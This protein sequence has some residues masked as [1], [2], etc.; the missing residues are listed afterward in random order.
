MMIRL[1]K[2]KYF[3]PIHGEYRHLVHHAELARSTEIEEENILL[4]ENGNVI[5]FKDG[6]GKISGK[7]A[8]GRVLVDGK[9]VG[10]AT[11]LNIS[12]RE[13]VQPA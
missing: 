13:K 8:T 6:K 3:I 5:S 4:A 10:V 7:V 9:G 12:N 1:T 2:P 11:G